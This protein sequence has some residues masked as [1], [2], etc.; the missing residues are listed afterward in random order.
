MPSFVRNVEETGSQVK[1][2]EERAMGRYEEL[3]EMAGKF[4]IFY[5]RQE[6][7]TIKEML[8]VL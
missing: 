4:K 5:G 3:T 7:E 8:K 1:V 6:E 2:S